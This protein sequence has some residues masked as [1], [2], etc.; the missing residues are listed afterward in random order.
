M[1]AAITRL[2]IGGP[3]AAYPVFEP[4]ADATTAPDTLAFEAII[5]RSTSPIATIRRT[6]VDVA[7]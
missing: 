2:G 5:C 7:A 3:L 4:K 1:M 6:F